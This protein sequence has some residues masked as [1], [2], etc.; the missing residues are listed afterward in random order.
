VQR[1]FWQRIAPALTLLVLAP[2][3]AELLPGATRFSA[4]FVF[5]V[6]M[7]VWGGGAVLIR[8]LVRRR[9]LGWWGLAWLGL[10]LAL[11]EECLIQQTSLAPLVIQLKH[12]TWAR[13][14][15]VNY[16][17]LAWA[18]VYETV[19]V[20]MLPVL[21]AERIFPDRRHESWLSR[22]GA[23]LLLILFLLGSFL[24]WFSWTQI[25]RVQVFHLPPYTP[26]VA[27]VIVSL[28][29]IAAA[30][31]TGL[32]PPRSGPVGR[33]PPAPWL[34]GLLAAVWAI[35][36]YGLCVLAF[37]I[38]PHVPPAAAIVGAVALTAGVI[39]LLPHWAAGAGW[40][41]AHDYALILGAL[42]GSMAVSFVGFIGSA[43]GD[44]WFKIAAD[45]LALVLLLLARR[46]LSGA[47]IEP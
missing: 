42:I 13:A 4:I 30:I 31:G 6:E 10:A 40:R 17:Y 27:A 37:G 21:L 43:D 44:L 33:A 15:G 41:R 3:M 38:A 28:L 36:W 22:A 32:R 9:R 7:A 34:V 1:T 26:P 25:A 12:E 2:L 29:A 18:L 39:A 24:A 8:A 45:L 16:V 23:I 11:A 35:L 19:W 46:R 47:P 20:T 5:P 14:Y